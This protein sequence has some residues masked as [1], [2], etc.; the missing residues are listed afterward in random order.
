MSEYKKKKKKHSS[1]VHSIPTSDA[2]N[3]EPG[4]GKILEKNIKDKKKKK[5]RQ[6]FRSTTGHDPTPIGPGTGGTT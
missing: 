1:V 6:I 5:I 3:V 4:P 2:S